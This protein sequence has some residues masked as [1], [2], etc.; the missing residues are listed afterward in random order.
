MFFLGLLCTIQIH[1]GDPSPESIN[2]WYSLTDPAQCNPPNMDPEAA[3][4]HY[5]K[6][7]KRIL[8]FIFWI[9]KYTIQIHFSCTK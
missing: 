8:I 9:L 5:V 2:L 4:Q 7:K 6:T 1:A 3:L